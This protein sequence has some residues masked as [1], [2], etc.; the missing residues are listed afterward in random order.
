[1][2]T[3]IKKNSK[4]TIVKEYSQEH[5][6]YNIPYYP[7]PQKE[8]LEI[9]KKY[10]KEAQKLDNIIFLGRLAEYKYHNMDIVIDSALKAFKEKIING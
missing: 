9:Y 7:I 2:K 4:T 1:M 10:L 3:L 6:K 8:N 5:N